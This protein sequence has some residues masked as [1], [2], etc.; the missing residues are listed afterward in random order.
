MKSSHSTLALIVIFTAVTTNAQITVPPGFQVQQIAPAPPSTD[1]MRLEGITLPNYGN[2]VMGA[3]NENGRLT[4]ARYDENGFHPVGAMS[5]Y[6]SNDLVMDIKFDR[7]NVIGNL[8]WAS[9]RVQAVQ[10]DPGANDIIKIGSNGSTAV[11]D[12]I[13]GFVA[14][15]MAISTGA[16][17]YIPGAYLYDSDITSGTRLYHFD[18]ATASLL[19]NNLVPPGRTDL[20]IQGMEFDPIG[21][22]GDLLVIVDSDDHDRVSAIYGLKSNLTWATIAAPVQMASRNYRG[23]AFSEGG[24]FSSR[25]YVTEL[26]TKSVYI[27]RGDGSHTLFASGFNGIDDIAVTSDGSQMFVADTDGVHMISVAPPAA[28]VLACV[29]TAAGVGAGTSPNAVMSVGQSTFGFGSNG[30]VTARFGFASCV[31]PIGPVPMIPGDCDGDGDIDLADYACFS[32]CVTGPDGSI[33]T[34]CGTFDLDNDADVDLLD[35]Q[36]FQAIFTGDL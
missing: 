10:P 26:V 3:Y 19:D 20:D 7:A 12:S 36:R 17:G 34:D 9:F 33:G 11:V 31:A 18:G 6:A 2:G 21:T 28:P 1:R 4:I 22:F 32:N 15:R 35:W 5:G 27:V 14:S 16:N 24:D 25:L 29:N 30:N 8:L 13:P 23:M